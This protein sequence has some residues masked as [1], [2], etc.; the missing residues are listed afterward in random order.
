VDGNHKG[1]LNLSLIVYDRYENVISREDQVIGLDIKPD[2]YTVF[3]STGVQIHAVL[4]VPKGNYWLRTGV[5]DQGS[6][7]VGTMEVALSS[8][9]PLLA[10]AK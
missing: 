4:A 3:Q 10:S 7:K 6:R 9:V 5:F 1:K 2:A 8:V